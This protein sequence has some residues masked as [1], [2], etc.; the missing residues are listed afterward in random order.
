WDNV[1]AD[2][3]LIDE[4][5]LVASAEYDSRQGVTQTITLRQD[6][7][8]AGLIAA[9]GQPL[10]VTLPLRAMVSIAALEDASQS[11]DASPIFS[12]QDDPSALYS[13]RT[14]YAGESYRAVSSLSTVNIEDL[15][16]AG[17]EYPAWVARRYLQL[18]DSLP[19]RVRTLAEQITEGSDTPFDRA[20]AV[21]RYLREIPYNQKIQGPALAQDGVDYFLFDAK[22]GYCDYYASAMAVMLRAVGVPAR[23]VRGYSQGH[24]EAGVYHVLQSDSHAWPEVFFPSYG[25]IEFEPTASE[26]AIRRRSSQDDTSGTS[27]DAPPFDNWA[28]E[29]DEMIDT[30]INPDAQRPAP[31]LTLGSFWKRVGRWGWLVLDLMALPLVLIALFM[32]RRHRQIEGLTVAER[33]Y[34]DL[35]DWGRRLLRMEPLAHQTPHEYAD[36]VAQTM[37]GGGRSVR[38]IADY[39][40]QERFGGK[41]VSRAM[42]EVAWARTWRALWHRWVAQNLNA[43]RR[44]WRRLVPSKH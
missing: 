38:Q 42:A 30:E 7:T 32:V 23:Y 26:P 3:I 40:V 27:T 22:Q 29:L 11:R 24:K 33:V 35:V 37:P 36:S 25:W 34:H 5:E 1:D 9:V 4:N 10:R 19:N 14:L 13:R 18:P 17:T 2:T 12:R 20:L 41:N 44:V 28:R 39:Y 15:R 43:V 6:L 16:Q 8:P 31:P 21:E